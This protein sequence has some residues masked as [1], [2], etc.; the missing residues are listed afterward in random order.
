MNFRSKLAVRVAKATSRLIKKMNRGSGVTLPGYVARLIDPKILSTL[1]SMITENVIVVMGTNGK[2]TSNALL[3]Q[4]LEKQGYKVISNRTGANMLNG[5]VSS[6][7]LATN[8]DG[9]L[10]A[11]YACI[12][13]DEIAAVR[14][15]P[16][17]VPDYALLTNIARDQ[18]DRFGE[19]EIIFQKIKSAFN[20]TPKTT[21][22]I[23]CDDVL[24]YSLAK[25][26][27]N[28]FI[29]YG[30]NENVFEE[31]SHDENIYCR[32]CHQDSETLRA[33]TVLEYQFFHYGQLG[34]YH[35]PVCDLKRP[36]PE[37]TATNIT[38]AN[39][40]YSFAIND[41]V[42]NST[43]PATYNIYNTL[44]AVAV[45]RAMKAKVP[46]MKKSIE[47]FDYGNNRESTFVIGDA[48][49]QLHLAKNPIG[50]QQK[51]ALMVK[52]ETPKD[53]I[54]L[55]NDTYQDG[56]D[57][58]WLWD[59]DFIRLSHAKINTLYCGGI[60]KY[61]VGLRLKYDDIDIPYEFVENLETTLRLLLAQGSQ[62]IYIILNYS[63]LYPTNALIKKL[64]N[65]STNIFGNTRVS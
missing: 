22:V 18:I 29:T 6:F 1:S 9:S 10:Q 20:G 46:L 23:N 34:I 44:S 36:T 40:V 52:D 50:F 38:R 5:I 39:G 56:E 14:V 24:S 45:L 30:I 4:V 61:D 21:L 49:V 55:I 19:V 47:S 3:C 13:V 62:N 32:N 58:S 48:K 60:R 57:V 11:D 63:N 54:F 8:L 53:V 35:C 17:L 7:V 33:P 2:T 25:E 59:V 65:P 16:L 37:Y 51:I 43:A 15:L 27:N 64:T 41:L 31:D 42:I 28:S 12:E 26:C